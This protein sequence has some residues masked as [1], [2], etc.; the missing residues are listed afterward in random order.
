MVAYLEF[1]WK[2]NSIGTVKQ[3]HKKTKGVSA[4]GIGKTVATYSG[5]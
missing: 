1:M 5:C 3:H 4:V 2:W